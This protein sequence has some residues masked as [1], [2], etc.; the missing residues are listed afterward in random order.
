[1]ASGV[2]GV[3]TDVG[4]V[5]TVIADASMG[6]RVALDDEPAFAAAVLRLLDRPEDAAA[7][8]ASGRAHVMTHFDRS[9]LIDDIDR[10]YRR[11]LAD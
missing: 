9:R 4:G 6:I 3:S 11:L 10:L 5:P 1:M 8:G 7:I 2:P